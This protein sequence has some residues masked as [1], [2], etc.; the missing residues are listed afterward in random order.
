M[1]IEAIA[2]Q[3]VIAVPPTTSVDEL[4]RTM[5]EERIGSVVIEDEEGPVGIVTDRDLVMQA[6]GSN[7]DI[8]GM[9]AQDLM[10]GDLVT[11]EMDS[12]VYE[13]VRTMADESVRRVP[14]VENGEL[15]GIVTM[16]DVLVLLSM[17]LQNLA[18]VIRAE[19]PAWE[20]P[21]TELSNNP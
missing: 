10:S 7:I 6:L 9:T 1:S 2:R 19:S 16:D 3:D 17:E 13:L 15:A 21:A 14:V 20:T 12:G 11:V 8:E 18:T 4:V 5:R